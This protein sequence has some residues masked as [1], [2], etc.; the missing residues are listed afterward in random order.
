MPKWYF[1]Q[2]NN[3][4]Y[5]SKVE[6]NLGTFRIGQAFRTRINLIKTTI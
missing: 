3:L 6:P 4:S 2:Y 1:F 5:T